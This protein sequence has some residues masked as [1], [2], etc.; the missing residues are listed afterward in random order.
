[1][2]DIQYDLSLT[3]ERRASELDD[4]WIAAALSEQRAN[5]EAQLAAS[6]ARVDGIVIT[7]VAEMAYAGQIH[8][9]RVPIEHGWSRE[10]MVTAF[11]EVYRAEY[12]NTLG[13]I[14]VVIVSLKTAVRGERARP[15]RSP[16]PLVT[17]T[18][19]PATT[20][21]VWFDGWT[22][23]AIYDR[24]TLSPGHSF[25]GPAI[26]EQGDTTAVIEPGMVARVDGYGNILVEM[27]A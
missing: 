10:R 11:Q 13:D 14:P 2:A 25:A 17:G 7:H 8:P 19:A 24:T 4:A 23:T 15:S 20:R 22:D 6:E 21:K 3:V 12:G 1:M 27:D 9:L 5:G 26:V 16:A 18:P